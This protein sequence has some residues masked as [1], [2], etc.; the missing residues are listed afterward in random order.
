MFPLV[1]VKRLHSHPY[2]R[3]LEK[4]LLDDLMK[5]EAVLLRVKVESLLMPYLGLRRVSQVII[6]AEL[7]GGAEMGRRIDEYVKP[8]MMKL[9]KVTDPKAK[10]LAVRALKKLL[11]VEFEEHV[12]GSPQ[13]KALYGWTDR[14]GLK[15]EQSQVRPTVHEIYVFKERAVRK[16]LV[17]LLRDRERLRQK[18]QRKPDPNMGAMQFAY[19]EEFDPNWIKRMGRLLGYPECCV[20]RFAEDRGH[21]VNAETRAANQLAEA[22]KGGRG[23]N[24]YAYPLGYFFP[25]KPDCP[26]SIAMG[27]ELREKLEEMDPG[28][29]AMYG[30]IVKANAEM[31]LR[32]PELV[33][34]YISQLKPNEKEE[35]KAG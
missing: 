11:E 16:E 2:L 1:E 10:L 4:Q 28:V 9:P 14:L 12:E 17:S 35:K 34:K 33:Q 19:P 8:H 29:G 27:V 18:V 25:C 24:P 15:S 23:I 26:A 13:Y 6:P 7:P 5:D 3:K 31:V 20:N 22:A 21:G 30:E 32:L